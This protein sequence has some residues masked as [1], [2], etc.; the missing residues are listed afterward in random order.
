MEKRESVFNLARKRFVPSFMERLKM[1]RAEREIMKMLRANMDRRN[2]K[3]ELKTAGS[4]AKGTWIKAESDI[5]IFVMFETEEDTKLLDRIVP[6]SFKAERG[7]RRYFRGRISGIEVE[8]IPLVRFEKLEDVKN[9]IDLSVL[10]IDYINSHCSET[11]K[12]DIVILKRF[13]QANDCYGSETH[14][15]GFS[16]YVLELLIARYRSIEGLFDAVLGWKDNEF[17]D[18]ERLYKS[19]TEAINSIGAKDNHLVIID[20]TNRK[21]NVC[22]SLSLENLSKFIL[23]VKLF[24]FRPSM[25]FFEM[26]NQEAE[27]KRLSKS[28]GTKL[29]KAKFGIKGPRDM[30]LSKLSSRLEKLVGELQKEDIQVYSHKIIEKER[31]ADVL[32]EIGNIPTVKAR[33][34]RGPNIWLDYGDLSN[35]FKRRSHVYAAEG[36]ILYDQ[37]YSFKDAN[38]FIYGKIK[39][40]LKSV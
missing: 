4:Y 22:G 3:V 29:F 27:S 38:K 40:I 18:L 24:T 12:K 13:C 7:T 23:A 6:K 11:Q 25:R 32:I 15:H 2:V 36:R 37:Y 20:P 39:S 17:I 8:V 35:F 30:F 34:V 21:R 1:E 9:T 31:E 19:R 33:K 16:G 26:K 5:D 14:K 28:R 10:H